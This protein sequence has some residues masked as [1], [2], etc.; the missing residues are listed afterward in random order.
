[1]VPLIVHFR[2]LLFQTVSQMVIEV[3]SRP[4]LLLAPRKNSSLLPAGP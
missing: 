1:M 2:W 4:L 3:R